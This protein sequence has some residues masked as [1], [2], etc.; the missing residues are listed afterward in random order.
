MASKNSE[1]IIRFS[2]AVN[3]G[4]RNRPANLLL[5]MFENINDCQHFNTEVCENYICAF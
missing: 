2:E 3:L 5:Y 1:P 4:H